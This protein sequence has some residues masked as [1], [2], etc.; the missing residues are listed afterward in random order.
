M[1][2]LSAAHQTPDIMWFMLMQS[3]FYSPGDYR[4][5][6]YCFYCGINFLVAINLLFNSFSY[7]NPSPFTR[8][9]DENAV[10]LEVN[11]LHF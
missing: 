8:L 9:N 2:A 5:L 10:I 11:E 6:N 4:A 1:H 7:G 3:N